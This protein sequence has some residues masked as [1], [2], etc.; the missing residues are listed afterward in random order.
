MNCEELTDHTSQY[1][2]GNLPDPIKEQ[3]EA[4]LNGCEICASE[5]K[6]LREVVSSLRALGGQSSPVDLCAGVQARVIMIE[7]ARSAWWRW[8]LKP[9]VA[10]PAAAV[11]AALA[12]F[13][14]WPAAA[15]TASD[16]TFAPEYSYYIGAHSH[17]QRH[18][19][20]SDPDMVFAKAE[21]QKA[22]LVSDAGE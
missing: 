3:F 17:L 16:K 2:S 10:A 6:A 18:Q 13:L 7:R 9:I 19:A 15:P 8:A 11:M 1:L 12:F 22:S 21:L 4:H 20:F 5:V 14:F